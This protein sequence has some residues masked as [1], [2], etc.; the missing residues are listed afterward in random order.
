MW[1]NKPGAHREGTART[2]PQTPHQANR[3][4]R[5][6]ATSLGAFLQTVRANRDACPEEECLHGANNI[7]THL[8][9]F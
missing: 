2:S 7:I 8:K 6:I 3:E 1:T 9:W 4:S 5:L